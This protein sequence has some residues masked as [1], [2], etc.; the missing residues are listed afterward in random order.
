MDT[1]LLVAA[2]AGLL[3]V[4]SLL[5]PFARRLGLAPSVLL[6]VVGILIGLAATY[7]LYTPRT[8]AFN[9]I[10]RVF[11][12]L[13][14]DSEKILY[15]F[16][17]VLLFQTTLTL[18]IR[19][20]FEDIGPILLM[21]VVAVFAATGFIGL[22]LYPVAG[23]PLMVCL[24]LGAIV[25][26]TDPV[27]VV[28]IFR[29]I[30]APA[31]LGRIVEGESLL[32]D[33]A[34][35]VLFGIFL[36][37]LSGDQATDWLSVT[38]SF[39][40]S[41]AGGIVVGYIVARMFVFFL[42]M[43]RD[44]PHAQVT[45]SMA[46]PYL[47]YVVSDQFA[48]VSAVVAVVSAGIVFNL[49]GPSRI[50]PD[51]WKFLNNVW[52]QL[53][54]WASSLIF[55]LA[56]ILIPA[57]VTEFNATDALLLAIVV[58]AALA[59]RALVIFGLMPLLS[60]AGIGQAIDLKFKTVTLWGGLRGAVTLAL[61]LSVTEHPELPPEVGRFVATLATGFV[62]FTLIAYGTTLK[63]LIRVM[64]LDKLSP[65]DQAVRDQFL[66]LS[67]TDI[68]EDIR[69][70]ALA[71]NI[72]PD[73][74]Q[75]VSD[76]YQ[77]RAD[78]A[79][80]KAAASEEIMD[81]GRVTLG[82]I[83]LA[84]RESQ[85]VLEHFHQKTASYRTVSAYL[86]TAGQIGDATRS[87]G[88]AGYRK[89]SRKPLKFGKGFHFAQWCQR[90]L[91]IEWLLSRLIA[92]R[93]D[94]LL[95]N[96]ITVNEL[97]DF[98][99]RRVRQLVG[100]RV[101]AILNDILLARKDE[102]VQAIDALRLQYPDYADAL[103]T[104]FLTKT[105]LRLEE[106]AY[107]EAHDQALI[108]PELHNTLQ[109]DIAGTRQQ[110]EHRPHL[111]LGLK[112]VDL[113]SQHA[114]FSD[115]PEPQKLEIARMMQPRFAVPGEVLIRQGD[116][117]EAAYLISSGAVE[118]RTANQLVRLG[119]GDVFGEISLLTGNRRSADVVA[120]GYCQL[121]VLMASDFRQLMDKSPD[122]KAHMAALARTR[123]EMNA[124]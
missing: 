23:V 16:L 51:N 83:A 82:L 54:F 80:R 78:A 100:E 104:E 103:E 110:L 76:D 56:A 47:I 3:I 19:R 31:R 4:I 68:R 85:V 38:I 87:E 6:A 59:S 26:T 115:L 55:V 46:L 67:L 28:A 124:S 61:A 81:K 92:E 13:P 35:I 113:V 75:K 93:F 10:A 108:G 109:D 21:A 123:Q 70:T 36:G 91:K 20:I 84:D 86:A 22:S 18:D 40:R 90:R 42:P 111:D 73:L 24:L 34:A 106:R 45:M 112:T 15:I 66:S 62:L 72:E 29:D 57:M 12:D 116:K 101:G 2:F 5:Q 102:I 39:F 8:N 74:A 69:T 1:P 48:G 37:I 71:Y 117:G 114:L 121:L 7:L 119:R 60:V 89:A 120:L 41:F 96:H 11:V 53:A 79:A 94:F 49:H 14:F 52:E 30:G 97:I 77:Q 107:A 98:N 99:N 63:P 33:A 44:L 65:M 58:V 43:M 122:V 88:R 27:A 64:G 105:G 9:E 95:L 17:P 32:N 118:V 50:A 25:A